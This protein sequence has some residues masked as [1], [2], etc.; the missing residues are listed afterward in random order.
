MLTAS[1][2]RANLIEALRAA[3]IALPGPAVHQ[4]VLREGGPA[5]G[6]A[7]PRRNSSDED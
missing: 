2:V 7:L 4:V 1:R 6:K 3:G 5:L